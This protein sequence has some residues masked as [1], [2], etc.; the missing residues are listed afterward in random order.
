MPQPLLPTQSGTFTCSCV[1]PTPLPQQVQKKG[2][3]T[4]PK[5]KNKPSTPAP[6]HKRGFGYVRIH[7]S[8]LKSRLVLRGSFLCIHPNSWTASQQPSW[9]PN[10]EPF[11][12]PSP[13]CDRICWLWYCFLHLSPVLREP[14]AARFPA[15]VSSS[16][17]L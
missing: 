8:F 5:Q 17:E 3:A 10:T 6:E 13:R 2:T 12:I 1:A 16:E 9:Q 4:K 7:S 14:L 15:C 11:L